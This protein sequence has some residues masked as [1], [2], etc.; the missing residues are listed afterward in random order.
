MFDQY[1]FGKRLK[2]F[3]TAAGLTQKTVAQKLAVSEQAVSKWEN[4]VCLPDAYNLKLLARVLR[5]TADCLLDTDGERLEV[6]ETFRIGG[7]AFELVEKPAA[8]FA[9]K[10]ICAKDYADISQ[11]DSA[12]EAGPRTNPRFIKI[13]KTPFCRYVTYI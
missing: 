1:D 9:G 11:F 5:T 2:T 6:I 3:R 8:I 7:A 13:F 4:G 10:I 12:I